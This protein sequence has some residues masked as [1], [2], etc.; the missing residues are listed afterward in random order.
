MG[1]YIE[2]KQEKFLILRN[3][4]LQLLCLICS[5]LFTKIISEGRLDSFHL[6][7]DV[8]MKATGPLH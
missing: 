5:D 4:S 6:L 2:G 3:M 1:I 7:I 8:L